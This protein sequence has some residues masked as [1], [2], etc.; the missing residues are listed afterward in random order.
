MVQVAVP[1]PTDPGERASLAMGA[2]GRG[3]ISFHSNNE[4]W[5][6]HCRDGA[7]SVDPLGIFATP[8]FA[9]AVDS[10]SNA[11]YD[12]ATAIGADGFGLIAYTVVD[13]VAG[14]NTLKVAHCSNRFCVPF[15]RAPRTLR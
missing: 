3:L 13:N 2:D 4:L 5:V 11:G 15:M 1:A 12:T 14:V 10:T 8:E 7:C 6:A 9:T